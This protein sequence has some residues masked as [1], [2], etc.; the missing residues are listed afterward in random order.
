MGTTTGIQWADHTFNPWEGCTKVSPGCEHCYAEERNKRFHPRS[1]LVDNRLAAPRATHWG[2]SAPRLMRSENNW[3]APLRWNRA[4][5]RDGVRRRVFCASL[6]DVFEDRPDL[7]EPRLR[8]LRLIEE[9]DRLDWLLLTKRPE[10]AERLAFPW[11]GEWPTNVW[12][13]TTAEDQQRFDERVP[14]LLRIPAVVHFLSVE[15]L[16][17]PIDFTR[18]IED[19][20]HIAR[21]EMDPL[22]GYRPAVGTRSEYR[23]DWVIVGG[24][25]GPHARPCALEWIQ[26]TVS[27][28]KA[29]MVPVFVKQLGSYVVSEDRT[30]TADCWAPGEAPPL[31]P[32]GEHWAWKMG[33]RHPKGGDPGE[34]PDLFVRQ[35][36]RVILRGPR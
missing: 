5:K 11:A 18:R 30:A 13:G 16:L 7:I 12:A 19:P 3:N 22:S 14:Y 17:G 2:P 26:Q 29:A 23:V 21:R 15:P 33:T 6:A 1:V 4:A 8:L 9:C 25:S 28:C 20:R 10:N 27:Q 34:F 31:A 36:P 35:V 24:E 32:N